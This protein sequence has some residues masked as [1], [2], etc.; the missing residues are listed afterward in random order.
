[1]R[2]GCGLPY[3][4]VLKVYIVKNLDTVVNAI[5]IGYGILLVF[6]AFV[7]NRIT[8]PMRIDTLFMK[9]ATESTRPLNLVVGILVA[10]YGVYSLM[11]R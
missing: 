1:M 11:A 9:Q 8:E 2:E 7:R 10:G 3:F 6:T 4:F 5:G